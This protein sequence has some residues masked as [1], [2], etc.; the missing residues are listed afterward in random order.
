MKKFKIISTCASLVL[1]LA[2]VVF[3][4]YAATTSYTLSVTG[5]VTFNVSN[6][7]IKVAAGKGS[8]V[9]ATPTYYYSQPA[10]GEKDIS[11]LNTLGFGNAS[12][13]DEDNSGN[14]TKTISYYLYVENLHNMNIYLK[15]S[16][17]WTGSSK[18]NAGV[19]SGD[20]AVS[21][22]TENT[23]DKENKF[24]FEAQDIT[25]EDKSELL[26]ISSSTNSLTFKA[27]EIKTLLVTLTMKDDAM[28][29]QLTNGSFKLNVRA[30]LDP[31]S[32]T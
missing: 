10:N 11:V 21:V 14:Q 22:A 3:G 28:V 4:V 7:F 15:F 16:Y 24:T 18:Y 8:S 19:T 30:D 26:K 9:P 23:S 32:S 12:F 25:H 20:G 27:N 5:T 29:Y 6:V 2:L 31:I 17:E 1:M 13:I